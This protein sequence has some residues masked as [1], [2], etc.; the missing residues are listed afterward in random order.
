MNDPLCSRTVSSWQGNDHFFTCN[1]T[2]NDSVLG[3]LPLGSAV[4]DA[5]EVIQRSY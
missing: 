3:V 2:C 4:L 5:L 1:F